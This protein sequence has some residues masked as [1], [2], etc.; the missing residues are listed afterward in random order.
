MSRVVVFSGG[1]DYADPWHPFTAT[2]AIVADA[3]RADGHEAIVVDTVDAL[4]TV[5]VDADLLVVNAGGGTEPHPL[6]DRLA[7]LLAGYRG[8]LLVLHVAATLLPEH[9]EWEAVLGG[10]WVRGES[11]HPERGRLR[12]RPVPGAVSIDGLEPFET[13]DEAYSSLRV[14]PGSAVLLVHDDG[15]GTPHPVAWTHERHGRRVAYSALGH[16]PE[17]YETPLAPELVRRLATWVL[18]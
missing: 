4:S 18:A 1:A 8:P 17:A 13:V 7:E 14:S 12:L 16:D 10:R 9:P 11:F 5:L 3:L 6:D 2:S 15:D